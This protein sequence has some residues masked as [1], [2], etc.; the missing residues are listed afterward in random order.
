[1]FQVVGL[2]V[3]RVNFKFVNHDRVTW[4]HWEKFRR[5]LTLSKQTHNNFMRQDERA[6]NL[7]HEYRIYVYPYLYVPIVPN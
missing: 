7:L 4:L 2:F 6:Y 5:V 3:N 1:M